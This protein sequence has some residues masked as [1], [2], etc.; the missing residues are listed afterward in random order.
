MAVGIVALLELGVLASQALGDLGGDGSNRQAVAAPGLV[1]ESGRRIPT[2]TTKAPATTTVPSITTTVAPTATTVAPLA[3]AEAP[4]ATTDAPPASGHGHPAPST[5]TQAP[6]PTSAAP[7]PDTT[8]AA[9][10]SGT[11]SATDVVNAMNQ[12]RAANG[13]APLTADPQLA[14]L[15]QNWA[16]HLAAIGA[17]V[18]QDLAGLN[19]TS[20]ANWQ[21]LEE[22]TLGPGPSDI[23]AGGMESLWMASS[24]HRTNI[25]RPEMNYVGVGIARDSAGGVY[26]VVDFGHR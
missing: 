4:T 15:A 10:A 5:T 14:S 23:G 2:T 25:L 16:N 6:A 12:D 24:E 26:A 17:L 13:L 8:A 3:A 18:H 19:D 1:V 11:A 9:P 20:M 21:S 22:N 7:P